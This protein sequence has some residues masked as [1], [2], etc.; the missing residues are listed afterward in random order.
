MRRFRPGLP[1]TIMTL[2]GLAVLISLGVWQVQR[3]HWKQDLIARLEQR[4][5]AEP[6]PL[7]A[8]IEDPALW[9]YRRVGVEGVFA[10]ARE[11]YVFA[12]RQRTGG[13]YVITPLI[14][15]RGA[16]VLINR[17]WVPDDARDP[18]ARPAG[19]IPGPVR[20]TG[21]VRVTRPG[22]AFTPEPDRE[23]RL[24]FAADIAALAEAADLG[25]VAPVILDADVSDAPGPEGGQTRLDL[26]NN[27]LSYAVT[28]FALAAV[29][30]AIYL[31]FGLRRITD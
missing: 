20:V 14:R 27:H 15:K 26:P 28:W 17:G 1:A 16:P 8:D 29:L 3:L 23:A 30:L 10:H 5:A 31:V 21:I 19:Q 6:V 22:N 13:W 12:G 2:I 4:L 9:D 24:F 11:A 18:A 7:P 25:A